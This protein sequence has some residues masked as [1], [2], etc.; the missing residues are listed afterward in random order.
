[1][2][3]FGNNIVEEYNEL[4]VSITNII[5][6]YKELEELNDK[7]YLILRYLNYIRSKIG[8]EEFD[9]NNDYKDENSFSLKE[10]KT[11]LNKLGEE[12]YIKEQ[13]LEATS[14]LSNLLLYHIFVRENEDHCRNGKYKGY[15]LEVCFLGRVEISGFHQRR[16]KRVS[17][18]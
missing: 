7:H 12:I 3:S 1:M 16:W 6:T 10:L 5:K 11:S 2:S 13:H 17:L 4:K 9:S 15:N 14:K 18:G 8:E